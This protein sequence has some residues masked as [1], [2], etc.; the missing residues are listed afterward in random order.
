MANKNQTSFAAELFVAAEL[1]KQGHTVMITFGNEKAIDILAAESGDLRKTVSVDVKGLMNPAPWAM[2]D[3]ANKKKHPDI[4]IFCYLNKPNLS[5]EYFIVP[6][7]KV[8]GLVG[9]S[10]DK[11]SSWINFGAIRD[12]K[13]KWALI[14]RKD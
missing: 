14:W 5:P 4:Y 6:K 1:A 3:Y 11:K 8:D 12:F 13:D 10:K 9:L 2:G 7:G